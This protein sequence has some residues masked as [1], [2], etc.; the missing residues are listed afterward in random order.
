MRHK[1][2]EATESQ[3]LSVDGS[4]RGEWEQPRRKSC[5]PEDRAHC[6]PITLASH[7]RQEISIW[8]YELRLDANEPGTII[9]SH[10]RRSLAQKVLLA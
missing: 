10:L 3:S 2:Q 5:Y 9:F 6:P 7:L 1:P 4:E 8:V